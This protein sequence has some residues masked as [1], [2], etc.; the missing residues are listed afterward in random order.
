[1]KDQWHNARAVA[2]DHIKPSDAKKSRKKTTGVVAASDL[3]VDNE[4][5]FRALNASWERELPCGFDVKS[6][7]ILFPEEMN[8]YQRWKKVMRAPFSYHD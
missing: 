8:A 5:S 3:V 6:L 1:L 4:L 7:E 2:L